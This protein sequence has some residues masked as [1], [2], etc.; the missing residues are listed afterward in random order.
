M[1]INL[2]KITRKFTVSIAI[3]AVVML[4]FSAVIPCT[5]MLIDDGCCHATNSEKPCC[6][7]NVKITAGERI[8]GHC[9][10]SIQQAQ[11]PVDIYIDLTSNQHKNYSQ[12][13]IDFEYSNS[14]F[15]SIQNDILTENYSPP[16]ITDNDV[17]LTNL[18]L[19]I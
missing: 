2:S 10:C 13:S 9:G 1:S 6:V 15:S 5:K 14:P 16:I 8:T 3:I 11:Q 18:N 7:K 12:T 17:Y 4:N 19:R